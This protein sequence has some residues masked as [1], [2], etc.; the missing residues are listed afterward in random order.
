MHYPS[1]KSEN[2]V[3]AA[4]HFRWSEVRLQVTIFQTNKSKHTQEVPLSDS[5]Q[6][7]KRMMRRDTLE[8]DPERKNK[9]GDKSD[10]TR[11]VCAL[12]KG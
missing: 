11:V 2:S 8:P 5:D 3:V 12:W 6:S 4:D 7:P 9:V 10:E 1:W